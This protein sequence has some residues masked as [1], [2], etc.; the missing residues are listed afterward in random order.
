[1]QKSIDHPGPIRDPRCD[2]N[3]YSAEVHIHRFLL[4]SPVRTHNPEEADFFYV[5]VYTTCDLITHQ[6]NDVPRV[7]R[8][9][10]EAMSI[11]M[12]EFPYWNRSSGRDHVFMFSQGFAGRLA[13]DWQL[14]KNAIFIVHNGE[15]SAPEYT[16]RKDVTVPPELRAYLVP[17]WLE[18]P[19][20]ALHGPRKYLAQFGGQV[21]SATISDHRGSNYSGGVRQYIQKHYSDHPE[22]RITGVRSDTYIS[23]MKNSKFCLAPEG[24]HPWSPRPY[25]GILMGCIPVIISEVQELAFEEL[26]DWDSFTVWVRPS[27]ISHLN[28]ILRSFSD[29][30]LLRRRLAM[31]KVWR[32]FWYTDE[33]LAYQA[34]LQSLYNR[35]YESRPERF[36][37]SAP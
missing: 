33:G 17:Y 30:E 21:L 15:F 22:Y 1:M 3:F 37:S 13:G 27:D 10:G 14:Y 35:K 8:H 24:W 18:N 16:P 19:I 5:P 29:N 9:F 12:Y 23:D 6:P 20:A 28:I 26:V 32:T 4:N 25:Y 11:I 36:F 2:A 34:L 7:G 31:K